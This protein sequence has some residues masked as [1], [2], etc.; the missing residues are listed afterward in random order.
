VERI[1]NPAETVLDSLWDQEW[2]KHLFAT[3]VERVK[4]QVTAHQ[5]QI[6]DLYVLQEVPLGK[7]TAALGVSP[8]QVYLTKHRVSRLIKHEA[9]RLEEKML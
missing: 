7:I 6:F 8:G 9:K 1:P 2:R 3:A 4:K 5:F